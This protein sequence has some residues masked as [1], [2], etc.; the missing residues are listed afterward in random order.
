MSRVVRG[1]KCETEILAWLLIVW[2]FLLIYG[3]NFLVDYARV[4]LDIEHFVE[5][6][7]PLGF[8]TP[9]FREAR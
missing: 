7:G 5:W 4:W 8:L 9:P 1:K 2:C 3:G 6:G